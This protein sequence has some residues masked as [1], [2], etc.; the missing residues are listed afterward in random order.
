VETDT[1]LSRREATLRSA[2]TIC[3]VGIAFLQALELPSLFAQGRQ[4]A[5]LSIVATGLCITL[6]WLLAATPTGVG[7]KLWH[8]VAGTAALVLVGWALSHAAALPGL[9][10]DRGN[11]A[12]MPGLVTGVFALVALVVAIASGPPSRAAVRGL[13]TAAAVSV[14]ITPAAAVAIVAL[15]PGTAG[16]ETVLASGGHIHSH[17]S[18]E[19]AIVFQPLPGGKGGH[20]V[21]KATAT[22]HMTA[23]G[24][25][26]LAAATFVF[27][28]MTL[29]FLRRRT[30]VSSDSVG[31]SG[32][33]M[34]GRLA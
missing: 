29:T 12:S 22:P 1:A 18:P 21:Y 27:L 28:Y 24:F 2:A 4:L 19:S 23:I 6:G 32:F 8:A 5:V 3:L 15:G 31:L 33:D 20:Y 10:S 26:L 30:I 16:G 14:A 25:G 13:A 34:N 9:A 11:W 17:G 7:R